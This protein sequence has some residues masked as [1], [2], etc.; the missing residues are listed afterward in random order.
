MQ[1]NR[2]VPG[3]IFGVAMA[4]AAC[5]ALPL[6]R[7]SA[8]P[9]P[10]VSDVAVAGVAAQGDSSRPRPY[11]VFESRNFARA[12]ARGTRTRTGEPGPTYWQQF[13]RYRIDAELVP[14]TNQLNG[15]EAVRY[16]NRSPDT[17]RTTRFFLN[18]NLFK[19]GAA[20]DVETPVTGGME[21]L[22]VAASGQTLAKADTGVGYRIEGTV[23][24]IRLPKPLAPRDSVD[25]DI[26]WNFQVPPDGAPREGST[27]DVFMVAYWYPQLAVYDDVNGWNTDPYLGN[28]EFYMGYADYDVNVS[29]PQGWLVGATGELTNASEVLSK[30]TRDRLQASRGGSVVHVVQEQDRGAGAN[31][32]T[33]TGFD[34]V[35]TWKF[36]ARNVRDFDFA[37]SSK[38]LWDAT[39]AIVGD[40]DGDHL[41]DTTAINT[42]YRP[43]VRRWA[44]DRSATYER[45]AVEFL[46][47][48][49]WPYPWSQMT[50]IDGPVS[51]SGMEYP[52]LTCIGG[53]RDTLLLYSV[54]I[55]ETA[56]MWFPMSVGSNERRFAWQ[57]EGL[58][59]FNQAEGMQAF[60]KGYDRESQARQSYL[61]IA[62]TDDEQ[63]LMTHG[64]LYNSATNAYQI[65]TYDK[66]ATNMIALRGILGDTAFMSAYRTYGLRWLYKHPTPYDFFNT[67][68]NVA[69]RDLSWF[70][71]TWW[72]ETWTLDQAIASAVP[73][74]GRMV[75]TIEDR[76]LAPMPVRLAITRIDGRVERMTIPETVW[77]RG[78]RSTTISLDS[79]ATIQSIEIDPERA[80]PDVD[81]S[82]NRWVRGER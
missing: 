32:A 72:Y 71:R 24:G 13:A 55:H 46:S 15:R 51:C 75:V 53:P 33:L 62:G 31:K 35:L 40:R 76:G 60:F 48:Y 56:H 79:P 30:Q 34:G 65:A 80:F 21:I 10:A 64:D 74:D 78:A 37:A 3:I 73:E 61:S 58:T 2:I 77:L 7:P 8:A 26:A 17:L 38:Y 9:A 81:R 63:P 29:L 59:R 28:A 1:P 6:R 50:A 43:E 11:P 20:R 45:S 41:T 16:Y 14:A 57:D 54:Q 82:N 67:F 39:I 52:M 22:R 36:R 66:M 69:S 18:Q 5:R 47:R 68:D 70:W 42:F 23:V 12:V 19:P 25:I 44:W 4:A 27:G 49:L